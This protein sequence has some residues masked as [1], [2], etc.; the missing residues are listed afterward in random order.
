M[1]NLKAWNSLSKEYQAILRYGCMAASLR[2]I[3]FYEGDSARSIQKF[4]DKGVEIYPLPKEELAK[5]EKLAGQYCI[6]KAKES[7]AYA[8]VLKSQMEYLKQ[9]KEW[10]DMSGDFG[11]GR[12]PTYVDT[13]SC[14]TEKN[15][16]L[17]L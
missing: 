6:M 13:C 12:T 2:A 9:Y 16:I 8:E 14:R 4:K 15:G 11:F 5:L 1:V 7:K 3:A 10:R 17:T